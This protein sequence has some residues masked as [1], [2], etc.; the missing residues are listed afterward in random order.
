MSTVR[1]DAE[2]CWSYGTI[3]VSP[4]TTVTQSSGAPSSCAATCASTVRAPCPMSDVPAYTT[5]DPSTSSRT[6]E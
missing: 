5:T 6:I 3:A 1:R 4:I 2:V